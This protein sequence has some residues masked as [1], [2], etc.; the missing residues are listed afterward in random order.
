MIVF[1]GI[2]PRR[3][4]ASVVLPLALGLIT[5]VLGLLQYRWIGAFA[6]A[7]R[8]QLQ[9]RLDE[10]VELFEQAFAR[11]LL[12]VGRPSR[13]DRGNPFGEPGTIANWHEDWRALSAHPDLV[14]GVVTAMLA[15]GGSLHYRRYDGGERSFVSIPAPPALEAMLSE[16]AVGREDSRETRS[17]LRPF[18]MGSLAFVDQQA[19][20]V[21]PIYN[22]VSAG[23][24]DFPIKTDGYLIVLIDQEYFQTE[25]V[26]ELIRLT[27]G[28]TYSDNFQVAIMEGGRRL[29]FS[30]EPE[31]TPAS[32]TFADARVDLMHDRGSDADAAG[33]R[34]RRGPWGPPLD[35]CT[36]DSGWTL[37]VRHREGS[38]DKAISSLR[39]R[40]FAV[41]G[42]VLVLLVLST[43]LL[44][45]ST[46]RA[47]NLAKAQ[48]E[49]AVGVSHELRTPLSVIRSASDNLA[50]GVVEDPEKVREYGRLIRHEGRRLS[51]MVEET[52]QF[53]SSETGSRKFDVR[54]AAPAEIVEAALAE[55]R[56]ML[57]ESDFVLEQRLAGNLPAVKIDPVAA[58]QCVENLINNALKYAAAG[59]WIEVSATQSSADEVSISVADRGP[60]IP[61]SELPHIFDPF[62]QGD[63]A[64]VA[65]SRGVGLGL[66]LT[67]RTIEA[68]GGR[69]SVDST[70]GAG[71]RFT[72]H[73]PV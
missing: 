64:G 19:I 57:D 9:S 56:A 37:L 63:R 6:D 65:K 38:L 32:F 24:R 61:T 49:F 8:E 17:S 21:R 41:S 62:F 5:V 72:L 16:C 48:V 45:A 59:K 71:T 46:R 7:Q 4:A 53:A 26:P 35:A 27:F 67:K 68:L 28:R 58:G 31:L 51:A 20:I 15:G 18:F 55:T 33:G 13:P 42:G 43:V 70:P 36:E 69:I 54:L 50:E 52:L 1:M 25:W 2:L 23:R 10:S 11:E 66:S 73:F 29:V 60:G 12:S 14:A 30:S 47:Q 44:V 40:N 22:S 39:R 3:S 34:S